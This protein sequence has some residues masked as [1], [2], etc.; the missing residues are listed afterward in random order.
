MLRSLRIT[1]TLQAAQLSAITLGSLDDAF[2]VFGLPMFFESYDELGY[3]YRMTDIQ[4]AVG[5]EQLKR[6]PQ[7]GQGL[8]GSS[9]V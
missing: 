1:R 7:M 6:L 8:G 2:N 3:N 9:P 5:R 4:A